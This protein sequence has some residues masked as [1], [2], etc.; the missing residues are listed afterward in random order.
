MVT[1]T[2]S[3]PININFKQI[4]RNCKIKIYVHSENNNP[5][6]LMFE[7]F[8]IGIIISNQMIY[9]GPYFKDALFYSFLSGVCDE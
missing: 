4:K 1:S 8:D 7:C 5:T 2:N 9:H 6:Y 3:N